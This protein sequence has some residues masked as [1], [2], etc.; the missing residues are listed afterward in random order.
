MT[1]KASRIYHLTDGTSQWLVRAHNKSQAI[2]H[3][4]R[5]RI[6]AEVADQDTLIDLVS[7]NYKVQDATATAEAEAEADATPEAA[8]A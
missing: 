5:S 6:K 1:E 3:I 8:E 4:V 2:A 7:K